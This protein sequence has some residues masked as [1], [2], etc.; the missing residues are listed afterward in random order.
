MTQPPVIVVPG[1]TATTLEDLYQVPSRTIW[2]P[3]LDHDFDGFALHPDNDLLEA[4]QP[5]LVCSLGLF[6]LVYRDIIEEL[7]AE[8]GSP[9]FPFAY[10]WRMPLE[11]TCRKLGRFVQEV[12][13]RCALMPQYRGKA[14]L[15]DLVGHSMGGLVVAGY[16]A[17]R[18]DSARVRRVV[19]L[20]AP[21]LGSIDAVLK[22]VAGKGSITG[23]A[24][25]DRERVASRSVPAIYHLLPRYAG[26]VVSRNN[27]PTDLFRVATWQGSLLKSLA[28]Y[29]QDTNARIGAEKLLARYLKRAKKFL[30][31]ADNPDLGHSLPDGVDGW[32][33]I[34]GVGSGTQQE[35]LNTTGPQ[36]A[37]RFR[38]L[39]DADDWQHGGER[40]GDG[41][42]PF[43]GACPGFLP[44]ERMVCVSPDDFSRWEI[45]DMLLS[46]AV[47]FH[48][49]LPSVNLVQRLAIKFLKPS[50]GGEVW[51]RCPPGVTPEGWQPP[52]ELERG[53]GV[54]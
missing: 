4:E 51:G 17:D 16:L 26:A 34:A 42:V 24:G 38:I 44:R 39:P 49:F 54:D 45:R 12:G 7:R 15:V 31:T 52:L 29:I 21:F 37:P 6:S 53:E 1:I 10:D 5:G 32:L 13:M 46:A 9:V 50:Y 25:R 23:Q 48:A 47:E 28:K 40:T 14:P 43:K 19:S 2:S 18:G 3:V 27:A 8:L 22:L 41:V 11:R 33:C 30:Q 20:G 36:G 35:I